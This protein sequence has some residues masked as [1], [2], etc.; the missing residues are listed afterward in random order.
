MMQSARGNKGHVPETAR[1]KVALTL[2]HWSAERISSAL[3]MGS[4]VVPHSPTGMAL[5]A[6]I[7]SVGLYEQSEPTIFRP[8]SL[9]IS[10]ARARLVRT[11][12]MVS[13]TL[14]S[15]PALHVVV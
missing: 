4:S 13:R 5:A 1:P 14:K 2:G 15:M 7:N 9:A 12:W 10:R 8:S 11:S 6:R 3:A